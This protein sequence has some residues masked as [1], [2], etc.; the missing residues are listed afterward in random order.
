MQSCNIYISMYQQITPPHPSLCLR[1]CR[2][3]ALVAILMLSAIGVSALTFDYDEWTCSIDDDGNATIYITRMVPNA[4]AYVP[5][6]VYR[7][8][9]NTG[10]GETYPVVAVCFGYPSTPEYVDQI[11][12][13][14]VSDIPGLKFSCRGMKSL[15]KVT[16]TYNGARNIELEEAA[17]SDCPNLEM[18]R[19]SNFVTNW[20]ESDLISPAFVNMPYKVFSDCPKLEGDATFTSGI[21]VNPYENQFL[22][23]W[24]YNTKN[25]N[26]IIDEEVS[27]IDSRIIEG[28]R[29]LVLNQAE[30]P[31][32]VSYFDA[33]SNSAFGEHGRMTS[34]KAIELRRNIVNIDGREYGYCT[35]DSLEHIVVDV[36]DCNLGF[37]NCPMVE[38][39]DILPG[40]K[41]IVEGCF[42]YLPALK[43][44]NFYRPS[45][46]ESIPERCF[47]NCESLQSASIPTSVKTIGNDAFRGTALRYMTIPPNVE[48][49]GLRAFTNLEMMQIMPGDT[50]LAMR[51][52]SVESPDVAPAKNVTVLREI[53]WGYY[54]R[55]IFCNVDNIT[56]GN[57]GKKIGSN[58]TT[59]A[60]NVFFIEDGSTNE[61]K[62]E[63]IGN[64]S[65]E[66]CRMKNFR[67][68]NSLVKLDDF[69]RDLAIE[70]LELGEN[71]ESVEDY[72]F[73]YC[74]DLHTVVCRTVT[75]PV[76]SRAFYFPDGKTAA[77]IDLIVPAES[78]EAYSKAENWDVFFSGRN[79]LTFAVE[80][81]IPFCYYVNQPVSRASGEEPVYPLTVRNNMTMAAGNRPVTLGFTIPQGMHLS[82]LSLNGASLLDKVVDNRVTVEVTADS[83][84]EMALG[85]GPVSIVNDIVVDKDF[86]AVELYDLNGRRVRDDARG[87]L[88]ERS[89]S[90][91]CR[92]VVR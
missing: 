6:T 2:S 73:Y 43:Y 30:H 21:I 27:E 36:P 67:M 68:P 22:G 13:I 48:S 24:F 5:G 69:G 10:L 51:T 32:S 4:S 85:E 82:K 46:L 3:L 11:E 20:I 70:A 87:V 42:S 92:K 12:E 19:T 33:G 7:W 40:V 63:E 9:P 61:C 80:G 25:V 15:K 52:N 23:Y 88:I 90:G 17:F 35:F 65:F 50:P 45:Q 76:A 14:S 16:F 86:E 41:T 64:Y 72:T 57:V 58:F 28:A 60:G 1:L 83:K 66:G 26:L 89:S 29:K 39:I 31:L 84:L 44:V 77:D 53:K 38:S 81:E 79:A 71:L 75:P 54:D 18:I 49:I 55:D 59:N 37:K 34:L 78:Y 47:F 91:K 62:V 56:I 74:P 8:N